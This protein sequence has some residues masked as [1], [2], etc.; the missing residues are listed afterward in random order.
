MTIRSLLYKDEFEINDKIKVVIPK[1]GQVLDY[2]DDYFWMV[3][4]ITAMPIDMMAQLDDVGIDFSQINEYELFLITFNAIKE[5]AHTSLI[6][7]DMKLSGFQ[8]AV[9]N[10]NGGIVLVDE[11]SGIIIDRA[12][13][14]KI[15]GALRKIHGL[16]KD[17][18]KPG[19]EEAKKYMIERARTKMRRDRNRV[20]DSQLED[21]IVAL[22]NTEQFPYDF[23][24]VRDLTIYQFNESAR[25]IIKKVDYDN[26]MHGVYAGTISVK[27]LSQDDLNW[28]SH[29]TNSAAT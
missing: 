5:S 22:V 10:E 27:D 7:G 20:D 1:V 28:L 19:N 12:I 14:A 6:F 3:S 8:T 11:A 18:R 23:Q 2:Q 17:R 29:K 21:L 9:N 16:K 15:A 25:Q 13:H 26:K 4:L 24:S